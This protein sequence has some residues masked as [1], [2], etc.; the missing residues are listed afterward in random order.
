M[1]LDNIISFVAE[2]LYLII[3]AAGVIYL[4]VSQR[5]QWLAIIIATIWIGGLAFLLAQIGGQIINSPRPFAETGIAPLIPTATDNGFPSD[6]TLL[7]ATVAAIVSLFN[8]RFGLLFWLLA[9]LVGLAR[10]YV[11][12]HHL[13]DVVGSFVLVG[14]AL[15]I[16]LLGRAIWRDYQTKNK[17]TGQ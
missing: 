14:L 12:A 4:A 17:R 13:I 7:L 8:W 3:I 16:Y 15:T 10:I 5:K 2:Y 11:R 6:H 1:V 9:V